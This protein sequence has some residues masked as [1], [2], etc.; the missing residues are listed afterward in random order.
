MNKKHSYLPAMFKTRNAENG[1]MIL[2]GY[3]I[4]YNSETELWPGHFEKIMPPKNPKVFEQLDVRALFNHDTNIVLGRTLNGTLSL[5]SDS[6]GLKGTI[7]I[8]PKDSQAVDAYSR[9][10]RGDITGCSFGFFP[11]DT[12]FIFK[13]DGTTCEIVHEFE[14]SEVS[15]CTFPAYPQ[16][17]IAARERDLSRAKQERLAQKKKILKEKYKNG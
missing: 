7:I 6:D 15:P 12:E 13:D 11:T 9:V 1:D 3:F 8:N 4:K 2:E 10:E 14:L 16:T 5:T 17:E